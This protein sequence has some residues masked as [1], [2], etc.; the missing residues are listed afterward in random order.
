MPPGVL[1]SCLIMAL[2]VASVPDS[3]FDNPAPW[4][5]SAIDGELKFEERP[6]KDSPFSEYRL[7]T[8]T[9]VS[10][11][12][13]CK[14]VFEMTTKDKAASSGIKVKLLIRDGDDER[15][16]Y[17]Q[18][19][20]PLVS[21][22]DYALTVR[23]ETL[24]GGACRIRF[25]TTNEEAPKKPD[26][27]V[28]IETMWGGWLFEAQPGR[29]TKLTYLIFADPAGSVPAFIVHGGQKKAAKESVLLAIEK[30]K[31]I[32]AALGSTAPQRAP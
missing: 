5:E 21:L 6:I 11:E 27:A 32:D 16:V 19:E 28:R 22:R 9:D 15:L 10:V 20:K 4:K 31:T 2:M 17:T 25:K 14:E 24:E 3:V 23:K 12:A 18:I 7:T 30:A 13:L 1:D 29:K 8:T 26:E